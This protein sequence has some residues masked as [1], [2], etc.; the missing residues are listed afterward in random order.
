MD[1]VSILIS[2]LGGIIAGGIAWGGMRSEVKG[3]RRDL[4]RL[5]HGNRHAHERIDDVSTRTARLEGQRGA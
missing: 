2:I 4:E 5:F 1:P 3:M